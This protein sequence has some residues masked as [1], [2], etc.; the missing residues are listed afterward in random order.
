[1]SRFDFNRCRACPGRG[2]CVP[3]LVLPS[4][5]ERA[6]N[7][8][9]RGE[10]R[11]H[12]CPICLSA[13]PTCLSTSPRCLSRTV[14]M[15]WYDQRSIRWQHSRTAVRVRPYLRPE[16]TLRIGRTMTMHLQP[17][18]RRTFTVRE[19]AQVLGIGRDATYAA[20]QAGTIPSIR[21]GR[22]V[23]IPREAIGHILAHGRT[24]VPGATVGAPGNGLA[25]SLSGHGRP[26]D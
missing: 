12:A 5:L 24:L 25:G 15:L 8:N 18:D 21:V 9:W 23:V 1:M 10:R 2:S 4:Q 20:V 14:L 6:K 11:R 3:R 17:L 13:C 16:F 7:Q 19:A 22:R 26:H